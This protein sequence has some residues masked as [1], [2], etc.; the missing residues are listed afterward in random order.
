MKKNNRDVIYKIAEGVRVRQEEFGLLVISKTT[1]A[2][3]FNKDSKLV[4]E[5]I[6]GK[7][8]VN[9]IISIVFGEYESDSVG[10]KIDALFESLLKLGLVVGPKG[11]A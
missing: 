5:L 4:F 3:S 6:D 10:Q 2:L 9:D 8:S 7:R 11:W 1:P